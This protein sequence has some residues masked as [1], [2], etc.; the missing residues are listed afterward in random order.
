MASSSNHQRAAEHLKMIKQ[1]HLFCGRSR[2]SM[3]II[4]FR[5][6]LK[7]KFGE[8]SSLLKAFELSVLD[9]LSGTRT[10]KSRAV[11]RECEA[12]QSQKVENNLLNNFPSRPH[13]CLPL[14]VDELYIVFQFSINNS[15]KAHNKRNM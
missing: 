13:S 7:G 14:I 5:D 12:A 15:R 3:K 11:E 2:Q 6:T 1:K 9:L 10:N 8:K 4:P